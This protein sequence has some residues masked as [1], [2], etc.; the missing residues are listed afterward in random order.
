MDSNPSAAITLPVLP[1]PTVQFAVASA[2]VAEVTGGASVTVEVTINPN[3]NAPSS[4]N[5]NFGADADDETFNAIAA[6]HAYSGT[7]LA[8]PQDASFA[9]LVIPIPKDTLR[10]PSEVLFVTMSKV[11]GQPYEIGSQNTVAITITDSDTNLLKL[12]V[13][14]VD[15][16]DAAGTAITDPAYGQSVKLKAEPIIRFGTAAL[17]VDVSEDIV[18]TPGRFLGAWGTT[19]T[20]SAFTIEA[21][22]T[23]GF[24]DA[25]TIASTAGKEN[26]PT[27]TFAPDFGLFA[28]PAGILPP[29]EI[30]LLGLPELSVA[31][32]SAVEG[33]NITVVVSLNVPALE[34]ISGTYTFNDGTATAN[35]GVVGGRDYIPIFSH[36]RVFTIA[37]G[38]SSVS[39]GVVTG[40]DNIVEG[41]ETFTTTITSDDPAKAVVKS[42]GGTATLT[43]TDANTA[44]LSLSVPAGAVSANSAVVV[45]GRLSG[46]NIIVGRGGALVFTD[47]GNTLTLTFTDTEDGFGGGSADG[48]MSTTNE[49]TATAIWMPTTTGAKTLSFTTAS[50]PIGTLTAEQ[51]T[52]GVADR[53]ATLA[54]TVVGASFNIIDSAATPRTWPYVHPHEVRGTTQVLTVELSSAPAADVDFTLTVSTPP[55]IPAEEVAAAGVYIVP[56]TLRVLAGQ[57]TGTATITLVPGAQTGVR[58]FFVTA[59]HPSYGADRVGR[60]EFVVNASPTTETS[61]TPAFSLYPAIL[62]VPRGESRSFYVTNLAGGDRLITSY[63]EVIDRQSRLPAG[64]T[65]TSGPTSNRIVRRGPT[66]FFRIAAPA[67]GKTIPVMVAVAAG[68]VIKDY[69]ITEDVY[70][71]NYFNDA[72]NSPLYSQLAEGFTVRVI[73]A[74]PVPELEV[75]DV[76]VSEGDPAR[77]EIAINKVQLSSASEV[78]VA[79]S[80]GTAVAADYGSVTTPVALPETSPSATF[81][82]PTIAD[83]VIEHNET[84]EVV[85]TETA[86][87]PYAIVDR[88]ATVTITD[89]TDNDA[90]LGMALVNSADE[91]I[92]DPEYDELVKLKAF[93]YRDK[94][95]T[96]L[97]AVETI[98]VT[99]AAFGDAWG[100]TVLPSGVITI[101][102]GESSGLSAEFNVGSLEAGMAPIPAPRFTPDI[103]DFK[104][105]DDGVASEAISLPVRPPAPTLTFARADVTHSEGSSSLLLSLV[106]GSP[107]RVGGAVGIMIAPDGDDATADAS[108]AADYTD[109]TTLPLA[110]GLVAFTITIPIIDDSLV[111]GDEVFTVTLTA[112]GTARPYILTS[113]RV[114]TVTITDN[115]TST[116]TLTA[117]PNVVLA[118][119][120]V[121]VGGA[122]SGEL[123][124]DLGGSV[125]FRDTDSGVTLTFTDTDNDGFLKTANLIAPQVRWAPGVPGVATLSFVPTGFSRGLGAGQ[126]LPNPA[127]VSVTVDK[128]ELVIS[129]TH[130]VTEGEAASLTALGMTMDGELAADGVLEVAARV[131]STADESDILYT[132]GDFTLDKNVRAFSFPFTVTDDKIIEG[133]EVLSVN[134]TV[135]DSAAYVIKGTTSRD[136]LTTVT[137]KDDDDVVAKLGIELVDATTLLKLTEVIYDREVQLRLFLHEEGTDVRLTAPVAVEVSLGDFVEEWGETELPGETEFTIEVG[138][139]SVLT[140]AFRMRTLT[141]GM[142]L[143]PVPTFTP[144]IGLFNSDDDVVADEKVSL[145]PRPELS[146]PTELGVG[147]GE[148]ATVV[149]SLAPASGGVVNGKYTLAAGTATETDDYTG[150]AAGGTFTIVAG[151]TSASI[152]I[153]IPADTILEADETFALSITSDD[154][155][156][157]T[158]SA[159]A[160][161]TTVTITDKTDDDAKL[162]LTLVDSGDT[163]TE[164]TETTY[165][166]GVQLRAFLYKPGVSGNPDTPLTASVDIVVSPGDFVAEWGDTDEPAA[167]KID[168]GQSV[169]LSDTFRIRSLVADSSM[170]PQPSFTVIGDF[171]SSEDWVASTAISLPVRPALTLTYNFIESVAS[172]ADLSI[173]Y[174]RTWA[175]V[176]PIEVTGVSQ[177]IT[178]EL[179][180][181]PT[182][183]VEFSLAASVAGIPSEDAATPAAYSIPAKLT[184]N[185][186][187]K[188]AKATITIHPTTQ[189]GVRRFYVV[190]TPV[191]GGVY[192]AGAAGRVEFIVNVPH[193]TGNGAVI[194]DFAF[195]PPTLEIKRGGSA[196]FQAVNLSGHTTAESPF[197]VI[198][199]DRDPKVDPVFLPAGIDLHFNTDTPKA[200]PDRSLSL[201]EADNRIF[202]F[203]N[204]RTDGASVQ[205]LVTVAPDAPDTTLGE[206]VLTMSN[207]GSVNL[208]RGDAGGSGGLF[209]TPLPLKVRVI[210][211]LPVFNF[212]ESSVTPTV[213]TAAYVHPF[214]V[215]GTTQEVTLELS[216]ARD[217][218]TVFNLSASVDGITPAGEVAGAG[219]YGIL[220]TLTIPR[221]SKTGTATI[222]INPTAQQGLRRFYVV[223]TPA[224]ANTATAGT[225]PQVEFRVNERP[226]IYN[227]IDSPGVSR[228]WLYVHPVEVTG[229]TRELTFELDK[230]APTGGITFEVDASAVSY[231]PADRA[232]DASFS[233]SPSRV[234][235]AAGDTTAT[236]TVTLNP[237]AHNG[238]GRFLVFL[239]PPPGFAVEGTAAVAEFVINVPHTGRT[240]PQNQVADLAFYPQ[241]LSLS[242]GGQGIFQVINI[243]GRPGVNEP[244]GVLQ[245]VTGRLFAGRGPPSPL[246]DGVDLHWNTDTPK[247]TPDRVGGTDIFGF[248]APLANGDSVR[249][250]VTI[251]P[252]ASFGLR[253]LSANNVRRGDYFFTS[254]VF[255]A[256][257]FSSTSSLVLDVIEPP[258][259]P[260]FNFIGSPA[261]PRVL[262]Y[263]HPFDV[264]G[265]TQTITIELSEPRLEDTVFML[266]ADTTDIPSHEAAG[267]NVHTIPETLTVSRLLT[268]GSAV[269]GIHPDAQSGRRRFYIEAT[270]VVADSVI[271]GTSARVE[272]RV[273]ESYIYNV[274]ES[275]GVTRT[276][277]YV[278]P[279]ELLAGNP[280][281]HDIMIELNEEAPLGGITFALT[282][283][284][285]RYRVDERAAA[286]AFNIPGTL[287]VLGGETIGTA[288]VT[289]NPSAQ[290]GVGRIHI[291]ATPPPSFAERGAVIDT[292]LAISGSDTNLSSLSFGFFPPILTIAQGGTGIFQVV[293]LRG[294]S[295]EPAAGEMDVF[296]NRNPRH[297]PRAIL[298]A[299]ID[300]H[301]D[302]TTPESAPD[303]LGGRDVFGFPV[304]VGDGTLLRVLVKVGL[305]VVP[306]VYPVSRGNDGFD[307]QFTDRNGSIFKSSSGGIMVRVVDRPMLSFASGVTVEEGS[308]AN[309]TLD[310]APALK[311]DSS[312]DVV[313]ADG[314]AT[315]LDYGSVT[316]PVTLPT[317]SASTTFTVPTRADDV[318]ENNETFDV[319]LTAI[320]GAPYT[321]TDDTAT[322][323]ITDTTD[324]VAELGIALV[325]A[326]GDEITD[327]DY[328]E[329]VKLKAFLYRPGSPNTPLTASEDITVTPV[330]FGDKWGGT[331]NPGTI[332]ILAEQSSGV[333]AEFN[334]RST[335]SATVKIAAPTFA[336]EFG[337]FTSLEDSKQSV[338]IDLPEQPV[339]P[340]LSFDDISPT[341]TEPDSVTSDLQLTVNI[342]PA[343][344]RDSMVTVSVS[345]GDAT[346]GTDYTVPTISLALIKGALTA[347]IP[348]PIMAD[349]VIEHDETFDVVLT[350]IDG[351]PYTITDDTATV[352]ITD[353]T[354]ATAKLGIELID[355]S[356]SLKTE[357]PAHNRRVRLRAFLYEDGTDAPLVASED[358]IVTPADF[359]DEWG[360][361]MLPSD[362]MTITILVGQSN[363]QSAA[364]RIRSLAA[365]EA[366]VPAPTFAPEFGGA[367]GFESGDSNPSA[368][369]TLPAKPVLG[370]QIFNF[371]EEERV[372]RTWPYVH[373]HEVTPASLTQEITIELNKAPPADVVFNLSASTTDIPPDERATGYTTFGDLIVS[374]GTR[375]GKAM[376]TIDPT[377]DSSG[378]RRF[379]VVA[380]PAVSGVYEED[381]VH[382]V[383]FVVNASEVTMDLATI[384]PE[385]LSI[386]QGGSATFSIINLSD[387]AQDPV[388]V[389]ESAS[390]VVKLPAGITLTSPRGAPVSGPDE[391]F[392]IQAPL[393][394]KSLE[395]EVK[396]K[397]DAAI[398]IFV[399][400]ED[401]FGIQRLVKDSLGVAFTLGKSLTL[402]VIAA[403]P[404]LEGELGILAPPPVV[405]SPPDVTPPVEGDSADSGS[406]GSGDSSPSGDSAPTEAR[407]EDTERSAP[408]ETRRGDDSVGDD[409]ARGTLTGPV[410]FIPPPPSPNEGA[411]LL[412]P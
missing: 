339:L 317:I 137:L 121:M 103:G 1:L 46:E 15:A 88:T 387:R 235:I 92:T 74:T 64:I 150:T 32:A 161:G 125:S 268:T 205:V 355:A 332:T 26:I 291:T 124:V 146:V 182:A 270:P 108:V 138:Q 53:P 27:P 71:T 101:V 398:G 362:A 96:A 97:M 18:V 72:V 374:G 109:V 45:T 62:T 260:T 115:D 261:T 187:E 76:S 337:G 153:M 102:A 243:Q 164:I 356:T 99:P 159:D 379:Y 319:V 242:P 54:V 206:N 211:V 119:E 293:N 231:L 285:L 49:L 245:P 107:L 23:A 377:A 301:F 365:G 197:F 282:T 295:R 112:M 376:I 321:I 383:E 340:V 162:R 29:P 215:T 36:L 33:S 212:V 143:L 20:P 352:T 50:L 116:L 313:L 82:V 288:T 241:R 333:S 79:L 280:P 412:R 4:V 406:D 217:E 297:G 341:H 30:T 322:V 210:E 298:P 256:G 128:S 7:T 12:R 404:Q 204:P 35:P 198:W 276:W 59:S 310:I 63:I 307:I 223:A 277:P 338:D 175:Y 117:A 84:F 141:G 239:T 105:D 238:V 111:E 94:T 95:S 350:A 351:A 199:L 236:V 165:D 134:F 177:E 151:K 375:I 142:A 93:L 324:D 179:S 154:L 234:T 209:S 44:A 140:D 384:Y 81:T 24:S 91:E 391:K 381:G 299:G 385:F 312:V 359:G 271:A 58:R 226:Y 248:P 281:R 326:A 360:D 176:H 147:E 258:P 80:E 369:I 411:L 357:N 188:T 41:D 37:K 250:L 201:S 378:F 174:A 104:S 43:V 264:T 284:V 127:R 328:N 389:I 309:L 397:G 254:G 343:L 336:P 184:V 100:D 395:I 85:L 246:P 5:L 372:A 402:E 306:G 16:A 224:K 361:T 366:P 275:P 10:E 230:P 13:T 169:G 344:P 52:A 329:A 148:V 144:V 255:G 410:I 158:V 9:N 392:K 8:L 358:I 370:K 218:E 221:L 228:T 122:L 314:T 11:A 279:Y 145:L 208:L 56:A 263:T 345:G 363:R 253:S 403:S 78:S 34:A 408:T 66:D 135:P 249:V 323:T 200:T 181:T 257:D 160:S 22:M 183:S 57:M 294:A 173:D 89:T 168:A 87:P 244:T 149:V 203:P 290:S 390:D 195:Y 308:P 393:D 292:E 219:V 180:V 259:P 267:A 194:H 409:P 382:R 67:D 278:Y 386:P 348:I 283:D 399:L 40:T 14:L 303:R 331:A 155:S 132:V 364:F 302:I 396:V 106:A 70:G 172:T 19:S 287:T 368:M 380:A 171:I 327:P 305:E 240:P 167:F 21:G 229:L 6:D 98:E 220:P 367:G 354:R 39:F 51:F 251:A 216:E 227:F 60:V 48:R 156:L 47:T 3:L 335:V 347:T 371:I 192:Q 152:E 214:E 123:V 166:Q 296:F 90:K 69:V 252:D 207:T 189:S 170:I 286:A 273:N 191:V 110:Q 38:A 28:S 139:S 330:D 318:I 262:P 126:F 311:T 400:T 265:A 129:E 55:E 269:I 157:A 316:S 237:S 133:D 388:G 349:S 178:L 266:T 325:D 405:A 42:G 65:L 346:L 83:D 2:T 163:D 68:A 186:N 61:Q 225:A 232:A 130:E 274:I 300:L 118:G 131:S 407:H 120:D 233:V 334:V 373:P 114:S 77:V 247:D 401:G 25:F 190:A 213:R 315:S 75:A 342:M 196:T 17:P 320:D 86:S 193:Q 222:T 73:S 202:S 136:V 185:A 353:T 113:A 394:G 289:L 272:F 304:P 31:A